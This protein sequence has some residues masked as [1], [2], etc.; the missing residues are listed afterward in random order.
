MLRRHFLAGALMLSV[1]AGAAQA[2]PA[3]VMVPA[4]A[5]GGWDGTARLTMDT[6]SKAGLF[7]EGAQFTNKG[8]AAGTIG[9]ADFVRNKGQDNALMFMG[10][11]MVGGIITNNSPV[12]LDQVT[13]LARLTYEY[14]AVAVSADS[15][16][17]T[18]KDLAEAI[19]RDPGKVSVGGGSVGSV[20]HVT[21]ALIAKEV[22]IPASKVNFVAFS[23]PE[24]VTS[25]AGGKITAAISGIS[26]LKPQADAGRIRLIAVTSDSRVAGV[27]VP[28]LKEQGFDIVLG[29]W[30]GV[31]GAPGMSEAGRKAWLERLDK[32]AASP[33]WKEGL[34][35]QGLED[36]YLS[37]DKF[38]SFLNDEKSRWKTVMTDL[39][40]AK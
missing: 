4:N 11:I 18:V 17:K 28:T 2:E 34:L 3:K 32:L 19:K 37:G 24:V 40:L 15:P 35:K 9:L 30:R 25:L 14:N 23:G 8:G 7:T 21:L 10:V 39:G 31:V 36:A 16:I 38:V 6:L 20:D 1:A 29:N 33:A 27:D 5:G 26:E 22:G 12:T 13:P